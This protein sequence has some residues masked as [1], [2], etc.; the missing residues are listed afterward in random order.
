L[1]LGQCMY[2]L[3]EHREAANWLTMAFL[4]EGKK[5]FE[6][7]DPKYLAFTKAQLEPPPGGWPEG[8]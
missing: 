4:S 5:L 2:E 7:D 6:G 8:W 3:G 1:R